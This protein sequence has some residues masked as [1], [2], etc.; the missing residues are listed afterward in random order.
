MQHPFRHS[1]P[2]RLPRAAHKFLSALR[3]PSVFGRKSAAGFLL[4][5][6]AASGRTD[7]ASRAASTRVSSKPSLQA[8]WKSAC[9]WISCSRSHL[10]SP[11]GKILRTSQKILPTW[12]PPK[13]SKSPEGPC[14]KHFLKGGLLG[15]HRKEVVL[16]S[17]LCLRGLGTL[18]TV[19]GSKVANILATPFGWTWLDRPFLLAVA[20]VEALSQFRERREF[21]AALVARFPS[22]AV[23]IFLQRDG[24]DLG[25]QVFEV[26]RELPSGW[27]KA[28]ALVLASGDSDRGVG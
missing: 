7:R 10:R 14:H 27:V 16:K 24:D 13:L 5:T 25:G 4:L 15:I 26:G 18:G 21:D 1:F 8:W 11:D 2:G 3:E 19:G 9:L 22:G 17:P 23:P 12:P 20:L 28:L 6:T